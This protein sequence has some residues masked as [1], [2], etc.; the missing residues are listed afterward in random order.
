VP[1]AKSLKSVGVCDRC[2]QRL[3]RTGLPHTPAKG[4]RAK[5]EIHAIGIPRF[6][7]DQDVVL[8]LTCGTSWGMF[9]GHAVSGAVPIKPYGLAVAII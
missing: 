6:L 4:L 2:G 9:L 7:Q 5:A 3:R 8:V 1:H